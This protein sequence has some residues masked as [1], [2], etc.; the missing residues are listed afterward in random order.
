M[1][2]L[3]CRSWTQL[4]PVKS[5]APLDRKSFLAVPTISLRPPPMTRRGAHDDSCSPEPVNA[6]TSAPIPP[7]GWRR[8]LDYGLER[9][10]SQGLDSSCVRTSSATLPN[11]L[12]PSPKG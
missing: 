11:W 9:D 10:G 5:P 6:R 12:K 7:A 3:R 1:V 2:Q 8:R 4:Q